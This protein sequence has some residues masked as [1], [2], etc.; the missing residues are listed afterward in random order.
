MARKVCRLGARIY[1]TAVPG[2]VKN[3]PI[4]YM[5][6]A[7]VSKFGHFEC[8]GF[9]CE[10][11][12][13][14][15]VILYAS[16]DDQ[17]YVSWFNSMFPNT[18]V[19]ICSSLP[20]DIIAEYDAVIKLT[21]TD[22]II[23]NPKV[24][25]IVH[26]QNR[27]NSRYNISL[28][29]FIQGDN[30]VNFT[31]V[32]TVPHVSPCYDKVISYIGFFLNNWV[33]SDLIDFI[34]TSKHRFNFIV[35]GDHNYSKLKCIPN[36]T[37][38]QSVP[39]TDLAAIIQKSKFLL[40]RKPPHINYDRFSGVFALSASFKKPIVLDRKSYD[41]YKLSGLVFE[42]NYMEIPNS[43]NMPDDEYNRLVD[44][45]TVFNTVAIRDNKEKI[46]DLLYKV[47]NM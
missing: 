1:F 6:I 35:W 37:V 27:T 2:L 17:G 33:D 42:K 28:T 34:T 39:T 9:L 25:S 31:S 7:I 5:K 41:I 46:D 3:N 18:S 21:S 40:S 30:I 22:S 20:T 38:L 11:L 19:V 45:I 12:K 16:N 32:Y 14:H 13:E 23:H 47:K 15:T 26:L 8:I 4:H 36:V 29:P 43:L 24:I 10:V 44:E